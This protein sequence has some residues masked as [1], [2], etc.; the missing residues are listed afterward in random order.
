MPQ[1]SRVWDYWAIGL[2]VFHIPTELEARIVA[3]RISEELWG[4]K[5]VEEYIRQRIA[6]A[7]TSD[8]REDWI[9]IEQVDPRSSC[10]LLAE[11]KTLFRQR[12]AP[13]RPELEK[14]LSGL[15][16]DIDFKNLDLSLYFN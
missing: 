6:G 13:C 3:K 8:E 1:T 14:A 15:R 11:T 10:N 4:E 5:A 9:F 2:K 12:L 7:S 16:S